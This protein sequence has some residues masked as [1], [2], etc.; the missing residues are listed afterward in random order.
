MQRDL[1]DDLKHPDG[2]PVDAEGALAAAIARLSMLE[3]EL[4]STRQAFTAALEALL[5]RRVRP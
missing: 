2:V 3:E 1:P 4:S 5:Q